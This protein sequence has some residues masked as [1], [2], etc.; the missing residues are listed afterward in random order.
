MESTILLVDDEPNVAMAL[1]RALLD[2]PY[3]VSTARGGEEA[4][5]AMAMQ[6]FKVVISD[7]RMPGMAGAEFLSIVRERFPEIVRI[8]LTGHAS[9]EATMKA[10]NRGEIYRFFTKPW[11]DMELKL[12]IRSAI[13]KYDLEAEN[14]R[15]LKTVRHQA[16]ELRTLERRYPGITRIERDD[17]GTVVVPEMTD[18]EVTRL[19][20]EYN[21]E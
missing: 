15:L 19:I 9:L 3:R 21:R 20:E 17:R 18:D 1:T 7:E 16:T 11:N 8:M 5:Q 4:L 10:V 6:R 2:E 13:E 12:A 14:R